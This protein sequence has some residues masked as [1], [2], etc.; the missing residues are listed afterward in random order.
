METFMGATLGD[1]FATN[2]EWLLV[3]RVRCTL[4]NRIMRDLHV[5]VIVLME[6]DSGNLY[7]G[8]FHKFTRMG[9]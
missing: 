4:F 7:A 9:S 3:R 2:F 8:P 1:I 5:P 6:R